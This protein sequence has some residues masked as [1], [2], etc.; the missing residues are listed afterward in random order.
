[1]RHDV[2]KKC[3]DNKTCRKKLLGHS[4][5]CK[6]M[7]QRITKNRDWHV[8]HPWQSWPQ[9]RLEA[10][11]LIDKNLRHAAL[12]CRTLQGHYNR[13]QDIAT[14]LCDFARFRKK[15]QYSATCRKM[16]RNFEDMS[17]KIARTHRKIQSHV[18]KIKPLE[19]ASTR[20]GTSHGQYA[21]IT[22]WC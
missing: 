15:S 8:S 13:L 12:C 5:N 9:K 11:M 21:S 10:P 7:S 20:F 2:A 3:R 18:A 17:R 16:T 22:K 19:L 4:Q 1:M 14:F 6:Y